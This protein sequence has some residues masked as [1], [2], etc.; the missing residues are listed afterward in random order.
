MWV[1]GV[2]LTL[3]LVATGLVV[4]SV[5]RAFPT[6]SGELTLPGLSAP[7]TVYRDAYGI[8]QIYA[9][10]A[11]DLFMA[12]GYVHAQDR[13]WEMDFRRHVTAGRLAELFGPSQVATDAFIRTLGWRRVAEQELDLLTAETREY[14]EAYAAGVNAWI[15]ANGGSA[16]SGAMGLEYSLLALTNSG[17]QVEPWSPVDTLSWLKAM[18]WDLRGNMEDELTRALL[19][20]H[21]LSR[22]QVEQLYPPYPYARNQP[23]V[24]SGAVVDGVFNQNGGGLSQPGG[25]F[26]TP[27]PWREAAPVLTAVAESVQ[28]LP[29]LL[30][31]GPGIGS[32]SWVISGDLT[33]TGKPLLA[34]DPHLAASMPGI[35][36]QMGL[37]CECEFNLV[38]FTFSGVPGVIIGHNERIAW[39]FT[40]LNPDVT[41]L[42][43]ERVDGDRYFHNGAWRPMQI[44]EERIE[45]AGGDPVVITVRATQ[46]G[47]LIS[48]RSADLLTI[49]DR[50][51]VNPSGSPLPRAEPSPLL[52]DGMP[53]LNPAAPAVPD[54]AVASPYGV[55]LRWTALDPGR[56]ADALVALN[57][58]TDWASFRSAASLFEV[59]SQNIVYADVD[60][61]IGY[62]A[63]GRI[64]RRGRGDGTWPM[65]GWDPAYNWTGFLPFAQLPSVFNPD[66]GWIVTA[67]QAVIGEQ[68][69]HLLTRDWSYGYRSQRIIDLI[70][71]ATAAGTIGVSD[72]QRIQFDNYNGFAPTLVPLLLQTPIDSADVEQAR[73]LLEGWDYQQPASEPAA[74]SAAA[75]FYNAT[76]RHLMLRTFDEL[77]EQRRP[78]GSDRWF[79]V[80]RVLLASPTAP[81]W[82]DQT[83]PGDLE[84]RDDILA[85]AMTDATAELR[86]RLGP[87]PDTWRWGD[88]H[89]LE[90]VHASFGSS[91]IAP[92]EMLFNRGP[93]GVSGGS[94]IVNAT[95]WNAANGYEVNA[96]PSMRMIVDLSDLDNSR[97]IQLTGNSG[98]P[99]H[100]N[101]VDQFELWRTGQDL[102][103]WWE[104]A[105]IEMTAMNTLTLVP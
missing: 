89:Q 52:P 51:A 1:V 80:M 9:R 22:V 10:T 38:G 33:E 8:P 102:P 65:P 66:E 95:G 39:G 83:T 60:G 27:M 42:Y 48:D 93:A 55:A 78:S 58:A 2:A 105:S 90:L 53:T 36:Y 13:F 3:A 94:S 11:H 29:A 91:G 43:L 47:P 4:W 17:Y 75:A 50:P 40:N 103:M 92:I 70:K 97:W 15:D 62:Q 81:W 73:R 41:D 101:N 98:H 85:R 6:H 100:S 26:A 87:D 46:H 72:I 49:A 16:G 28:A 96:V 32:N 76:W 7:V 71:E 77:P 67:N 79:E 44:R 56:T 12:Q 30:G 88:L 23:I 5:R 99:F 104:R 84:T 57:R 37:H 45:V 14:L 69:Q 74:S 54:R 24:T 18:A 20:A 19:L 25:P 82:D 68:Y 31:E 64:P 21:G 86:S 59:P 35:W 63:P 34:N 61:N